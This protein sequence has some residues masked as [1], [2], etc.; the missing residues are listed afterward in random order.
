MQDIQ[1]NQTVHWFD[2]AILDHFNM[3]DRR[4][5]S[6][7]YFVIDDFWSPPHGPV[8]LHICGEVRQQRWRSCRPPSP[9]HAVQPAQYT[10][11]GIMPARLTPLV[12]AQKYKALVVSVEHR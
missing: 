7:R 5:W 9:V 6:Q 11:P 10:C 8:I 2:G 1:Y 12:M 3:T 4:T